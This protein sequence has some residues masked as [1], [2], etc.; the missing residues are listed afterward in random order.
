MNKALREARAKFRGQKAK[1]GGG[2]DNSPLP[3]GPYTAEVVKCEVGDRDGDPIHKMH[4]KVVGGDHAGRYLFPFPPSLMEADGV[5]QAA[6][7]IR[8]ILGEVVPGKKNASGELEV[9]LDGFLNAIEDLSHQ[10]VGQLIEVNVKNSKALKDDGTP[11]QNVY[12]NRGLGDDA[13]A[14]DKDEGSG[15]TT[16]TDASGVRAGKKAAPK[17]KVETKKV[18]KKK[19]VK[20]K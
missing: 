16:Q 12:I 2:F 5:C 4:V 3:E 13:A 8:A 1:V 10:C 9:E 15:G 17:K 6:R 14:V 20:K 18:A 7:N 19:V 11:W